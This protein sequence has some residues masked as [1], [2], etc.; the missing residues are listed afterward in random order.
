MNTDNTTNRFHLVT[1]EGHE[2]FIADFMACYG[3]FFK[4]V[5]P[6][7]HLPERIIWNIMKSASFAIYKRKYIINF[8]RQLEIAAPLRPLARIIPRPQEMLWTYISWCSSEEGFEFWSK[9]RSHTKN[10]FWKN[11]W[12]HNV[13]PDSSRKLYLNRVLKT[14]LYAVGFSPDSKLPPR[15][16]MDFRRDT[17]A[18]T[19]LSERISL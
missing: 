7:Y 12:M 1:H 15:D 8:V 17:A 5:L 6:D 14:E 4:A 9:V 10:D 11:V 2:N 16:F 19:E 18:S 13:S 3:S